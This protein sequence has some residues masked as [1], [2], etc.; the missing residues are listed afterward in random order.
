M[1]GQA[2]VKPSN[3]IALPE[4]TDWVGI[5]LNYS[6]KMATIVVQCNIGFELTEVILFYGYCNCILTPV[7]SKCAFQ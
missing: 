3:L 1:F 4:K 2:R 7:S 6:G 5:S